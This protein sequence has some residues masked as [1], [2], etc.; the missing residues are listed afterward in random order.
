LCQKEQEEITDDLQDYVE[1]INKLQRYIRCSLSYYIHT[2][3]NKQQVCQFGYPKD[4]NDHIFIHKDNHDQIEL[5]TERNNSYINSHNK[6][7]F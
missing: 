7:Q 5:V 6:L 2:N 4:I 3:C 1:L